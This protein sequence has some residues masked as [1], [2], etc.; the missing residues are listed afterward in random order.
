M[1]SW[2]RGIAFGQAIERLKWLHSEQTDIKRRLSRL[3]REMGHMK[4]WGGRIGILG[5]LGTGAAGLNIAP[6]KLAAVAN[7]IIKALTGH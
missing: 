6:D 3:E 2:E 4:S 1:P 7:G 5:A